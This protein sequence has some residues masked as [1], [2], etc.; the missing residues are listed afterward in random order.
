MMF[1]Q[2]DEERVIREFF[3]AHVGRFLD[4]GAYD[5]HTFS[6]THALALAGWGGVC[7][8]ASPLAFANLCS[9]YA[10]RADIA[11]VGAALMPHYS[12]A[13]VFWQ[14]PDALSTTEQ[15][16]R[17]LWARRTTFERIEVQAVSVADLLARHPGPFDLVS[18]DVEGA[19][20][21]LALA[22]PLEDLG[23]RLLC[24]EHDS[25]GARIEARFASA[26]F[27]RLAINGENL[28]LG[29]P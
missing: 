10:E 13:V 24:V 17:D 26:G 23:V 29:R 20:A 9:T 27:R 28:L 6:N 14:T 8:E 25:Q 18:V 7:V 12:G 5:G 1:S 4:V 3:G 21:E 16:H 19:S 15:R 11:C 2:N 22:L